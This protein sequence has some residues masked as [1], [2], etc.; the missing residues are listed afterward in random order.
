MPAKSPQLLVEGLQDH[1]ID[2]QYDTASSAG[3][4]KGRM[5]PCQLTLFEA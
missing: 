1:D 3:P 5:V 4:C 2:H